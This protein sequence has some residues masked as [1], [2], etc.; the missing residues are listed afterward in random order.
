MK[1]QLLIILFIFFTPFSYAQNKDMNFTGENLLAMVKNSSQ[2]ELFKY[3]V[4]GYYEGF[5]QGN[6]MTYVKLLIDNPNV[7]TIKAIQPPD[8]IACETKE[9]TNDKLAAIV[10]KYLEDYPQKLKEDASKLIASAYIKAFQC[11][12]N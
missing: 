6:Y 4:A 9:I 3:Y 5:S 2:K 12:K 10:K 11:K 1:K 8:L 7:D